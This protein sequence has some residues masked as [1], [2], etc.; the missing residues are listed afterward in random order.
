MRRHRPCGAYTIHPKQK[1]SILRSQSP[2]HTKQTQYILSRHSPYWANTVHINQ[3]HPSMSRHY[4]DFSE[5]VQTEQAQ[6]ILSRHSPNW[7]DSV[8]LFCAGIL[9]TEQ[10]QPI[11]EADAVS[12]EQ[13]Q[14]MFSRHSS[15]LRRHSLYWAGTVHVKK[16]QSLMSS[17][18]S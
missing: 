10:T 15:K 2:F 7:A 13:T 11:Y 9:Y 16:S 12:Y 18:S 3:T 1:H 17:H 8:H 5:M 4:P 14:C 6:Y